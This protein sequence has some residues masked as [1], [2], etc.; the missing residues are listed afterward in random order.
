MLYKLV[1]LSYLVFIFYMVW[2]QSAFSPIN[3][4]PLVLGSSMLLLLVL[5]KVSRGGSIS[6]SL[7]DPIIIWILFAI[8]A[9]FSGY[10]V[11]ANRDLLLNSIT[12]YVQIIILIVFVV[13]FSRHEG[14]ARFFLKSYAFLSIVYSLYMLFFGYRF[15][16]RV[17]LS[18]TSNPNGDGLTLIYGIFCILTLSEDSKR[19]WMFFVSQSLIGLLL[20]SIVLTGSRKSFLAA[21]VLVFLWFILV[22]RRRFRASE[23]KWK[24][25]YSAWIVS[26]VLLGAILFL[27]LTL[28]TVLFYRLTEEL[29]S[30]S[31][32]TRVS[33]YRMSAEFFA[34]SPLVGIG[35]NQFRVLSPWL[36]Y[37]H[38]T[39]A[40][41]ISCTGII[42]T[43]LYFIPYCLI[44][45]KLIAVY[46]LRRKS[47]V[48]NQALMYIAL[49]IV[50]LLL[51]L[52][53]IHFYSI[54]DN[55]M[56]ALMIS[57]CAQS[58]TYIKKER[59][60]V[61]RNNEEPRLGNY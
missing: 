11:A 13:D 58:L 3:R 43:I 38:S 37:S 15:L 2:Y 31:D 18:A 4:A 54:I 44:I 60:K 33:M 9:L 29:G 23:L 1:K 20:Y 12:T 26:I 61:F 27:P 45:Y 52:G 46:L 8:Y 30:K 49:M 5:Y 7:A 28:D 40:E 56:F 10:I 6:F 25:V 14:N 24:F 55:I 32:Q 19:K 22:F 48:G 16:G 57:F 42:G 21:V 50:M 17:T 35:F 53:V 34:S 39:Y 36:T 41:I 51:G 59:T 47:E